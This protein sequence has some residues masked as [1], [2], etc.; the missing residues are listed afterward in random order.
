M[1]HANL[2]AL[3]FIEPKLLMIEVLHQLWEQAFSTFFAPVTLT[4]TRL[5]AYISLTHIP[6][7]YTTYANM[8]FILSRLSNVTLCKT[9][10]QTD[11]QDQ[12]YIPHHFAG[13]QQYTNIDWCRGRH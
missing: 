10:R 12:Y 9:D 7:R 5:P 11:R 6:W 2:T 3:C 8:N 1:L 13:G 4:L